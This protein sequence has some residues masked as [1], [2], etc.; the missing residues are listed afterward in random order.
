MGLR[1]DNQERKEI[2]WHYQ[3]GL[4]SEMIGFVNGH[5]HVIDHSGNYVLDDL[6]RT[7]YRTKDGTIRATNDQVARIDGRLVYIEKRP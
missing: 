7:C 5:G 4:G 2:V 3:K 6:G 1:A